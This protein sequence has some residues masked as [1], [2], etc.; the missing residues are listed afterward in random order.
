[1]A[2]KVGCHCAGNPNCKLCGGTKVY[3]YE[4]GP[5]GWMPFKCPTC[6]GTGSVEVPGKD[7]EKCWTCRGQG[8]VDPANPPSKGM[9]DVIW[10]AI[11]GAT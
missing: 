9:M 6:A 11:F 4:P 7:R 8:M 10:K 1:M 5:R 2:K 3:Q